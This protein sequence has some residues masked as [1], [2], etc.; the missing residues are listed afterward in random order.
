MRDLLSA[1]VEKLMR[2]CTIAGGEKQASL[3]HVVTRSQCVRFLLREKGV[4]TGRRHASYYAVPMC[5]VS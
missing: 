1:A 5:V 2:S 3:D 4:H